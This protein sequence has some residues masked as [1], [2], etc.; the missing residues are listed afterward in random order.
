[1]YH[2]QDFLGPSTVRTMTLTKSVRGNASYWIYNQDTVLSKQEKSWPSSVCLALCRIHATLFK[3]DRG[4]T[5]LSLQARTQAQKAQPARKWKSLFWAPLPCA[6][7]ENCR[8]GTYM[9]DDSKFKRNI[10]ILKVLSKNFQHKWRRRWCKELTQKNKD[11]R[12]T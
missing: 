11:H 5:V 1:M 8:G 7:F 2:L 12:N 9:K 10:F 4:G 3:A 6:A